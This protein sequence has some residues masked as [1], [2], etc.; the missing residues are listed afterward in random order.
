MPI[1]INIMRSASPKTV[2]ALSICNILSHWTSIWFAFAFAVASC[3]SVWFDSDRIDVYANHEIITFCRSLC[4]H[5]NH[6]QMIAHTMK[7]SECKSSRDYTYLMSI[8][9]C[10]VFFNQINRS[11]KK[12]YRSHRFSLI[13]EPYTIG[14]FPFICNSMFIFT[15]T[16][17]STIHHQSHDACFCTVH[18]FPTK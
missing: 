11:T 9:G 4:K 7:C 14:L 8:I 15:D 12:W 10:Y 18:Y 13:N 2:R 1:I 16:I 17:S 5:C 6:L 3:S